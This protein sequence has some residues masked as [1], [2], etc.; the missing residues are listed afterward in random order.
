MSFNMQNSLSNTNNSIF[1]QLHK[2]H[3]SR[4]KDNLELTN[5][6]RV[7]EGANVLRRV[8]RIGLVRGSA[9]H[10]KIEN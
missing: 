7:Y 2:I 4:E 1:T 9:W 6:K 8:L 5:R 10:F 3:H